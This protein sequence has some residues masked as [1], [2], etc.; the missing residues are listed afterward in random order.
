MTDIARVTSNLTPVA[1]GLWASRNNRSVSYP[2]GGHQSCFAVEENSFW[3][4]HRNEVITRLVAARARGE[5]LFDLGAGNGYVS[6]GLQRAG[7]ESVV[8][9]PGLSGIE[10]ARARGLRLLIHST[11]ED[12]GF[13]PDSVGA[14]GLFDVLEHVEDDR[15]FLTAVHACLRP[16]GLLFLTV[17]ACRIL[18]S[19]E[20]DEAGHYRRY[21]TRLL[22]RT[23]E[24]CGFA[25]DYCSYFFSPLA[26]A[27]LLG[28][29]LPSAL[30]L[31]RRVS[32]GT[33]E[34][35]HSPVKGV[36]KR[37]LDGWLA[38]EARR[39]ESGKRMTLG[40]SCVAVAVKQA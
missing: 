17:P 29:T 8:V 10:H 16:R 39:I 1:E 28:R 25:I 15:A 33:I 12:A 13:R 11:F 36:A 3:F 6:L 40:S 35:E 5:T 30:G 20:D 24:D 18:W 27:V 9:E 21:G 31:R 34:R 23:L 19:S 22:R 26:P 4:R 14:F 2:A 32:Q 37:A 7:I 38:W